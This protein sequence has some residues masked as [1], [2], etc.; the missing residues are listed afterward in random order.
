MCCW[1]MNGDLEPSRLSLPPARAGEKLEVGGRIP[2]GILKLNIVS[3]TFPA[4][5]PNG[6]VSKSVRESGG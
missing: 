3:R 6:L 1:P 2:V 4:A 5:P